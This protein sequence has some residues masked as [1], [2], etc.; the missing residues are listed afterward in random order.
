[1]IACHRAFARTGAARRERQERQGCELLRV[2]PENFLV[3]LDAG[4]MAEIVVHGDAGDR[5]QEQVP[6]H[7]PG[8]VER[9]LPLA[10]VHR[11][12]RMESDDPAPAQPVE[13]PAELPG[14]VAQL[15]VVVVRG[16][17]DAGHPPSHVDVPDPLVEVPHAGVSR[18]CGA[19]DLLRLDALV[20]FPDTGDVEH[21]EDET[22]LIAQRHPRARSD[23]LR[24]LPLHVEGH[25][26]GPELALGQPH[27]FQYV[28]PGFPIHEAVEGC[29]ATV[30]HQL[31][32]AELA[33]RERQRQHVERF[34]LQ[35]LR[36]LLADEE[37]LQRCAGGF[38]LHGFGHVR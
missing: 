8:R 22:L 25:R 19:V 27:R 12:A 20:R 36:F 26:D 10:L 2:V 17:P 16:K 23:P 18:G 29:E 6:P 32:V 14:R 1:M 15:L 35:R 31:E 37:G 11:P 38:R 33:L 34:V 28:G 5:V 3:A 7:L 4:E 24:K 30:H 21:R 9:Q 13:E